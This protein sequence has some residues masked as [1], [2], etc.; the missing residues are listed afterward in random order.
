MVADKKLG[1]VEAFKVYGAKLHNPR[2]AVS[3]IA[4]DGA[5]V[6][7]CWENFFQKGMRY[8][9]TLS[10]WADNNPAGRDL[11]KSHIE[12]AVRDDLPVRLVIAHWAT[13]G[14]RTADYF[15][16]RPDLVG[17]ITEFDGDKFIIEFKKKTA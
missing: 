10:R 17:R 12:Q 16:V 14:P 13:S 1:L 3:S 6:I 8:V 4:T 15:H 7:S 9:D 2:W 11:L 5:V